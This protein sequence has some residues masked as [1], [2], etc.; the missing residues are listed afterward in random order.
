[1]ISKKNNN[2]ID[3]TIH[4]RLNKDSLKIMAISSLIIIMVVLLFVGGGA[5]QNHRLIK[6]VWDAGHLAL[7]GLLSFGYFCRPGNACHSLI[8]KIVF[9]TIAS[10]F[11]G[12]AIEGLQLLIHRGFSVNDIVNDVIGGYLG[13]LILIILNKQ[14]TLI[15]RT[16]ASVIFVLFLAVGLRGFEKH[17]YD[18]MVMQKQF[19]VLAGFESQYEMER[20]EFSRVNV[21]RSQQF[22]KSGKHSLEVDYLLGRY[23]NISLQHLKSDWSGYNKLMFSVYSPNYQ[24]LKFEVKVYDKKHIENGGKYSDRFNENI[25]LKHGWNSIEIAMSDIISAPKQRSMDI[26]EIKVFSIFTDN[27]IQPVTIYIDDIRLM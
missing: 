20:W 21:R 9:T 11:F 25:T 24:D 8:Y 5:Q 7:F 23:P 22:V 1:M 14:Q 4:V 13:L 10:L 2:E 17:L 6:D 16:I 12:A 27:L 3:V 15:F 18:E 19:P 26:H